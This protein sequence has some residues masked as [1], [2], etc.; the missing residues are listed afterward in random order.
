[1]KICYWGKCFLAKQVLLK[2]TQGLNMPSLVIDEIMWKPE[3]LF[4][5]NWNDKII[6]FSAPKQTETYHVT[7]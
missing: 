1:M 4:K 6:R 7:V 2:L 3:K 5:K